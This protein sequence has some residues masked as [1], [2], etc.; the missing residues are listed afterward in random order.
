MIILKC[1]GMKDV[2]SSNSDGLRQ[3]SA[4]Q[5]QDFQLLQNYRI[6]LWEQW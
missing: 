1:L 4:N 2:T 3:V 6:I 5:M